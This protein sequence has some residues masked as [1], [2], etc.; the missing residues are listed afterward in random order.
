MAE[1]REVEGRKT[2]RR[3]YTAGYEL[4]THTIQ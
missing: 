3:Y 2:S 1:E 4:I